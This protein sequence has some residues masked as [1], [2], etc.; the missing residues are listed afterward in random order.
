MIRLSFSTIESFA[1]AYGLSP[2]TGGSGSYVFDIISGPDDIS[3]NHR[4][5][6]FPR[7]RTVGVDVEVRVTDLGA[8][9]A[10]RVIHLVHRFVSP[11]TASI[12]TGGCLSIQ[13]AGGSG[14]LAYEWLANDSGGRSPL[15]VMSWQY[16]WRRLP[17][18]HRSRDSRIPPARVQCATECRAHLI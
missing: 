10:T 3:L 16:P 13:V 1:S 12:G 18:S 9:E 2:V 14:N 5:W 8:P 11:D 7:W 17:Q 6:Y 15:R 4:E